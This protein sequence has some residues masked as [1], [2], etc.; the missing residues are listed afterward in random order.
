MTNTLPTKK[1]GLT[2]SADW[3]SAG[4]AA[5]RQIYGAATKMM[6]DLAGVQADSRVLDVAAGTGESTLMAA[7]RVG[8]MGYVIATDVFR[9]SLGV[10]AGYTLLAPEQTQCD[11]NHK[12]RCDKGTAELRVSPR[13]QTGAGARGSRLLCR[14]Q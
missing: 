12:R 8:P 2:G 5:R 9:R 7:R 14:R 11:L 13:I 1:W 10:S 4:Q 3:W 6:L